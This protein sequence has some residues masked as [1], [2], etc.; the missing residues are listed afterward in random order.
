MRVLPRVAWCLGFLVL[1]L[2]AGCSGESKVTP[3]PLRPVDVAAASAKITI[4]VPAAQSAAR[5]AKYVSAS[6]RSLS[7]VVNGGAPANLDLTPGSP[8][9]STG[10]PLLCSA[11]VMVPLGPDTFTVTLYDAVGG[12]GGVG[13]ALA[14]NTIV[15]AA[16]PGTNILPLVVNGVVASLSLS[17]GTAALPAGASGSTSLT[18]SAKDIDGNIIVGPGGYAD[19]A[20]N[21][22]TINLTATQSQPAVAAPY[23]A[24]AATLS[25]S[26]LTVPGPV[27][28]VSYDGKAL[29]ATQ[30]AATVTGGTIV[31]PATATLTFTPTVYEY[32][33]P[34][35]SNPT[36]M[37]VG[38]DK[39]I[40]LSIGG[41]GTPLIGHFTP[42]GPGGSLS[43]TQ[44]PT[45]ATDGGY[46]ALYLAAGSDGNIWFS[47]WNYAIFRGPVTATSA[48]DFVRFSI[49]TNK[50]SGIIDGGDGNMYFDYSYFSGPASVSITSTP[51]PITP[52]DFGIG[53]SSGVP[54]IGPDGRIWTA[55]G[56]GGCCYVPYIAAVPTGVSANHSSSTFTPGVNVNGVAVGSDGNIWY[57]ESGANQIGRIAPGATAVSQ[58]VD[59]PL[60]V[61]FQPNAIVGG[62][63]GAIYFTDNG[64]LKIGRVPMTA[65]PGS[66]GLVEYSCPS[67]PSGFYHIIA[68]PDGN[69]WFN[70]TGAAPMVAKLAL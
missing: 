23:T 54:V 20:G 38:P 24:G 21:P 65:T 58:R 36:G 28:T 45:P 60:G 34:A 1:P 67:G 46:G 22:L 32:A 39:Q 49:P 26:T 53:G 27:L 29:L 61:P 47:D 11:S 42:V 69:V 8:N 51:G 64:T 40:W 66:V 13:H 10:P 16:K 52:F 57:S 62:P 43:L 44:I 63:D 9:C 55:A 12:A 2:L 17:L 4:A 19:A 3:G 59:L 35:G 6:T 25:A 14:T 50:P 41:V 31:P 70:E 56:Q 30:I 7:I 48:A 15:Y 68:G 37:T 5:S 18:V 33:L